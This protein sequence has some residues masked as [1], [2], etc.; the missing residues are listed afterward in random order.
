MITVLFAPSGII[1]IRRG[2]VD[3]DEVRKNVKE[4]GEKFDLL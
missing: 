1:G 3:R 4:L 2:E